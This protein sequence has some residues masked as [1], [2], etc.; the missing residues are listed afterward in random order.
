MTGE[1]TL[2]GKVLAIGGLKEKLLAAHRAGI[3]EV[4]V[5]EDNRKDMADIPEL[6][7]SEMKLHFVEQMDEVLQ[8][9]LEEKLPELKEE[10]L[11]LLPAA[12]PPMMPETLP[13][14]P[15]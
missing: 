2:R 12:M 9:A 3:F 15:Q 14:S 1:I 6:L 11:E 4:I 13:I 7:K 10:T 8:I 5:P